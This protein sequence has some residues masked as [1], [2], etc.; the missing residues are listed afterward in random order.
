MNSASPSHLEHLKRTCDIF[1]K[2]ITATNNFVSGLMAS[3]CCIDA[4][5][6][7]AIVLDKLRDAGKN[8]EQQ[9]YRLA[10]LDY[11]GSDSF[12]YDD[13]FPILTAGSLYYSHLKIS[14]F[15]YNHFPRG[16]RYFKEIHSIQAVI[17][18]NCQMLNTIFGKGG[19][20]VRSSVPLCFIHDAVPVN[21]GSATDVILLGLPHVDVE[22]G[23]AWPLLGHEVAHGFFKKYRTM[24][25]DYKQR[26]AAEFYSDVFGT[27]AFGPA[28]LLSFFSLFGNLPGQAK[29]RFMGQKRLLHPFEENRLVLCIEVLSRILG[30]PEEIIRRLRK[31]ISPIFYYSDEDDSGGRKELEQDMSRRILNDILMKDRLMKRIP[32]YGF[33][34]KEFNEYS[35]VLDTIEAERDY[36]T[37]DI[38]PRKILNAFLASAFFDETLDILD[39]RANARITNAIYNWAVKEKFILTTDDHQV[40]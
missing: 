22:F 21:I 36:S 14:S 17:S 31:K 1:Q 3:P 8:V 29:A 4:K 19:Q 12:Q 28:F 6:T 2:R 35:S 13:I 15:L 9:E 33:T 40:A 39:P 16:N 27:I 7:A 25:T 11:S 23:L 32:A 30:Y 38:T 37:K 26:I 24:G 18:E 10:L 20:L 34:F 5:N